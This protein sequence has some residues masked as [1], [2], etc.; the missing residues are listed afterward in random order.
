[1]LHPDM[2]T[3]LCGFEKYFSSFVLKIERKMVGVLL[4][5]SPGVLS[6]LHKT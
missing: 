4:V 2:R 3:R 6:V 5:G 1:M